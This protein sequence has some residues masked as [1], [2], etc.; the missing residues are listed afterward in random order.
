M[1]D[2]ALTSE[3]SV[4]ELTIFM[5]PKPEQTSWTPDGLMMADAAA[6][7]T[8]KANQTSTARARNLDLRMACMFALWQGP[9]H[10]GLGPSLKP[11]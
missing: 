4:P 8:K 5:A 3:T 11:T 2:D 1:T 10:G 7:P 9:F 6:A